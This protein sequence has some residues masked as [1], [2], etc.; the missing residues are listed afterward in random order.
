MLG[1]DRCHEILEIGLSLIPPVGNL[2]GSQII[3]GIVDKRELNRTPFAS[4][5]AYDVAFHL[6]LEA[7]ANWIHKPQTPATKILL[8]AD[9][10]PKGR[11]EQ[12]TKTFRKHRRRINLRTGSK[13]ALLFDDLY[14]GDSKYC[15][16]IQ[17]ADLCVYFINR[18]L[19]GQHDSE[20]FYRII[21]DQIAEIKS[22]PET[23]KL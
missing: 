15:L 11:P 23:V 3:C 5:D 12:M 9:N 8:I 10:A 22:W 19:Q 20:R 2:P 17:L 4:A 1:K 18:H 14:F 7:L 16:G 21:R 13:Y 6:Y